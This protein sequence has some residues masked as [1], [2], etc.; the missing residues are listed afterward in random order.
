MRAALLSG[1]LALLGSALVGSALAATAPTTVPADYFTREVKPLNVT[2][3]TDTDNSYSDLIG[4][5]GGQLV[6]LD[7]AGNTYTLTVPKGALGFPERLTMTPLKTLK[8]MPFGSGVDAGVQLE[9]EGTFFVRPVQLEVEFASKPNLNTLTPFGYSGAGQDFTTTMLMRNPGHYV[10]LLN[11]FSGAG[12][13]NGTEAER[14]AELVR[15]PLADEERIQHYVQEQVGQERQRQLLG[16]DSIGLDTAAIAR[17]LAEYE[18]EVIGPLEEAS[19]K[20]CTVGVMYVQKTL[21]LERMRQLLGV[22]SETV[23]GALA[24]ALGPIAEKC[25]DEEAQVCN[26]TGDLLRLTTFSL[27]VER[28]AQMTGGAVSDAFKIKYERAFKACSQ[29][30]VQVNSTLTQKGSVDLASVFP[31]DSVYSLVQGQGNTSYSAAVTSILPIKVSAMTLFGLPAE[32]PNGNQPLPYAGYSLSFTSTGSAVGLP[33]DC[34][35]TG[36]GTTPGLIAAT[37]LPIFKSEPSDPNAP[38]PALDGLSPA[39]KRDVIRILHHTPKMGLLAPPR[40]LD[41]PNTVLTL[42]VGDPTE[43]T[44]SSCGDTKTSDPTTWLDTWNTQLK[45]IGGGSTVPLG[46]ST[47]SE[48][49]WALSDWQ[50]TSAFPLKLVQDVPH[51]E[52]IGGSTYDENWHLDITVVHTPKEIP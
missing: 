43:H 52:S 37:F 7:A 11:H 2:P 26:K 23:L 27:S 8:G 4:P 50:K 10:F 31:Q 5:D 34:A 19:T 21:G 15:Q 35:E 17:A 48:P 47:N 39:Q 20:S 18:K 3:V 24:S 1:V 29:F 36:T 42:G 32:L 25:L 9:P 28:Q 46:Q 51:H 14:T 33:A 41:L 22:D 12:F 49:A 38:D 30:E 44:R 45:K 40:R 13:A 16:Q 6:T